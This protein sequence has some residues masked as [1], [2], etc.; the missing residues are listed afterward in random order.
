MPGG[1]LGGRGQLVD[2]AEI[3]VGVAAA[4]KAAL[5]RRRDRAPERAGHGQQQQQAPAVVHGASSPAQLTGPS[6]DIVVDG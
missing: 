4:G 1:R 5:L 2:G 6:R 3:Q